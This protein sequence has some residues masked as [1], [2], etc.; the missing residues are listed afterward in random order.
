MRTNTKIS[1]PVDYTHEGAVAARIN[2]EQQLRRSV[3]ACMLWEDTFYESGEDVAARIKSIIPKVRPVTVGAI[4]IEARQKLRHIPLLLAREMAR[5]PTHKNL[6]GTLLPQIIQRPDEL[7]EF[8]SIY[9]K[10]GRQP[11]SKQV[12]LG[13]AR[14]FANFS[15]YSLAKYDQENAVKLRDVLFLCHAKPEQVGEPE[16]IQRRYKDGTIKLVARHRNSLNHKVANRELKTPD[17]WETAL[18]GGADKC[19]TFTRLIEEGKLGALAFIRNLRN[20]QQA[21]V[22]QN[23]IEA[24]ALTVNIER[25]LPFRFISAARAVPMWE[26][27]IENMMFRCLDGHDKLPGNTILVVD[28]SGSMYTSKV[29]AKS[30]I[31]RS[32]AAAALAILLREVCEKVI[33]V[34][35]SGGHAIVPAR[36]GF[37]LR[38]ALQ[39]ST[40]HGGTN[41]QLA[42]NYVNSITHDRVIVITDEQSHDRLTS[43][44]VCEK[45]YFINVS[46]DKNG[47]G[48]GRWTHIDGFSESILDYIKAFES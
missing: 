43:P 27:L 38:D 26:P 5:I 16:Y 40:E 25:V 2:P 3:M 42:L 33:V 37:A 7:T 13:L 17:T 10:D 4:A 19:E 9:W 20:M 1:K 32:D 48:Y 28:N 12:K 35:F 11:L 36:R 31:T 29:S 14:A 8:L 41:T 45:A 47:I 6:V 39:A 23:L 21:G 44:P 15:E 18:S 46:T 34:A 22:N 30:D 24:Y